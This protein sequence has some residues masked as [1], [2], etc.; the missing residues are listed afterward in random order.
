MGEGDPEGCAIEPGH[1]GVVVEEF[2]VD[3]TRDLEIGASLYGR[4]GIVF[5]WSFPGS[6]LSH[7]R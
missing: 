5:L 3:R 2:G 6:C 4:N 7:G 1:G